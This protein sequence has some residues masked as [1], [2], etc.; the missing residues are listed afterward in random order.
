MNKPS[1]RF[2]TEM[3]LVELAVTRCRRFD[4]VDKPFISQITSR[5][6]CWAIGY[7]AGQFAIGEPERQ[8]VW[9]FPIEH[10]PT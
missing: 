5:E 9:R 10:S 6:E 3:E 8:E 2:K 1:D 4:L 7:N